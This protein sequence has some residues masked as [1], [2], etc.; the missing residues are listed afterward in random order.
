MPTGDGWIRKTVLVAFTR[1]DLET[2]GCEV[3]GMVTHYADVDN[4]RHMIRK[5]LLERPWDY[6]LSMDDDNAP[7]DGV[8]PLE[9]VH[10]GL[11]VVGCPT[12]IY[13]YPNPGGS[14]AH[15]L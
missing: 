8:N 9:L 6:W 10:L 14:V 1:S 4:N 15:L 3:T 13:R 2:A 11:D 12:P 7:R 5:Q